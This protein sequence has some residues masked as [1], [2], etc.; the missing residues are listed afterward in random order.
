MHFFRKL[1]LEL[2]NMQIKNEVIQVPVEEISEHKDNFTLFSP[3]NDHLYNELKENI[4]VHGI[5]QPLL[6][7]DK[8]M[9]LCGHN[10]LR[11]AKDLNYSAVSCKIV[12]GST[13][14]LVQFMI[15]DNSLRLGTEK[16]ILRLNEQSYQLSQA[17]TIRDG[18]TTMGITKSKFERYRKLSNLSDEFKDLLG[19]NKLTMWAGYELATREMETQKK[20]YQQLAPLPKVNENHVKYIEEDLHVKEGL[21][22]LELKKKIQKQNKKYLSEIENLCHQFRNTKSKN[23]AQDFIKLLTTLITDYE[24][25]ED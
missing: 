14:E 17:G 8:S 23:N 16:N 7:T 1:E 21:S 9:L 18:A 6:I 19:C 5:L 4:R 2:K 20:Y 22:W 11:I 13:S 3:L 12:Q 25:Q 10:R 15:A 24:L